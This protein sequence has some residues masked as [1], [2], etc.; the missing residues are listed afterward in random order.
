M[1]FSSAGLAGAKPFFVQCVERRVDGA[2]VCVQVFRIL[3][4][5]EQAGDDLPLG[6]MVL[7]EA[8]RRGAVVHVVVGGELAQRK[9][10]AVMLLDDLDRAGLLLH[11]DRHAARR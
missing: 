8:E 2:Q 11:L 6:G 1:N 4:D 7:Q 3:L 9:L 10:G 5:V